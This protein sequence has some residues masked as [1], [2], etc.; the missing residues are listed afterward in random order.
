M[1]FKKLWITFFPI[2]LSF[3]CHRVILQTDIIMVSY[4]G[5]LPTAA[6]GIPP[7]VMIF[8]MIV[9]FA[10]APVISILVASSKSHDEIKK[11]ISHSL[12]LS[13]LIGIFLVILGLVI[14][15][16][17][18][19]VISSDKAVN[20]YAN[21]ALFYLTLAIPARLIVFVASMS[22]YA[23]GKGTCVVLL[24]FVSLA[25]N[26]LLNW[27]F[28]YYLELGFK[29]CYISTFIVAHIGLVW[30]PYL[31]RNYISGSTLLKIPDLNWIKAYF[32]KIGAEWW[33]L[34]SIF[35][36]DFVM[37]YLVA[38]GTG[39]VARLS[40]YS[41]IVEL[42][43]LILIPMIALM[44]STAIIL[45]PVPEAK[46][47]YSYLKES[48]K[49]G[50]VF[51]APASF[52]LLWSEHWIG[53]NVYHLSNQALFWWTPYF[54]LL[55]FGLPLFFLNSLQRGAWQAQKKFGFISLVDIGCKC[56]I[57]LPILYVGL[58][59]SEPWIAWSGFFIS[60]VMI[61]L[62][63]YLARNR[64]SVSPFF[65]INYFTKDAQ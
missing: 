31:L 19:Q 32:A 29:G 59:M 47:I 46:N 7:K 25:L 17:L 28:M 14:Y 34:A 26:V 65:F 30:A 44:R 40:A 9:A 41:V 53:K 23:I 27:F 58:K 18:V 61:A 57:H 52:I 2:F 49:W 48:A 62:L 64:M 16:P 3:I 51:L 15:P 37:I 13:F 60:E 1:N 55:S 39:S 35:I 6:F 21:Q 42:V 11:I 56:F 54:I 45:A 36:L 10:M 33:R 12:T 38:Q 43:G 63:L 20:D 5:E 24:N 50:L 4:L 22:L 8:D